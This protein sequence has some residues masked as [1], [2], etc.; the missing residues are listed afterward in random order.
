MVAFKY[1]EKM[2][3]PIFS[4]DISSVR[5]LNLNS[6]QIMLTEVYKGYCEWM[7]EN[8]SRQF[9][10]IREGLSCGIGWY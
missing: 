10:M 5:L 9:L 2:N 6:P 3:T 7:S 4:V 8:Q 1:A